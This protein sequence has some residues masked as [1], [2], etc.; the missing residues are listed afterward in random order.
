MPRLDHSPNRV[1]SR[2]QRT[3]ETTPEEKTFQRRWKEG[4]RPGRTASA[5]CR[6]SIQPSRVASLAGISVYPRVS[7]SS[8][9]FVHYTGGGR[10]RDRRTRRTETT[11]R[12]FDGDCGASGPRALIYERETQLTIHPVCPALLIIERY[13]VTGRLSSDWTWLLSNC[14]M[15]RQIGIREEFDGVDAGTIQC[16]RFIVCT[17]NFVRILSSGTLRY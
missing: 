15:R 5:G 2:L 12:A 8:L 17:P 13:C 9:I 11:R 16:V 7:I 1:E 10:V 3:M 4:E 14:S 6:D